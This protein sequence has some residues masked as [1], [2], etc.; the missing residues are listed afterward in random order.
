M[1][2]GVIMRYVLL[3]LVLFLGTTHIAHPHE[4]PMDG[5]YGEVIREQSARNKVSGSNKYDG[6]AIAALE[7][8]VTET[9]TDWRP[10]HVLAWVYATYEEH[11]NDQ[12]LRKRALDYA[13]RARDG[14]PTDASMY[15]ILARAY[16]RNNMFAEGR[17]AIDRG[18]EVAKTEDEIRALQTLIYPMERLQYF[19]EVFES[20]L[21]PR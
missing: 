20:L 13:L 12:I 1:T 17:V 8:L 15:E 3:I 4:T 9:P 7:K 5:A 14:N 11:A 19:K 16:M 10:L 2:R 21:G 18:L 6:Q